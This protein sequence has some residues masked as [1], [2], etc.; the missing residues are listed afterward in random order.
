MS[1]DITCRLK[2]V[3]RRYLDVGL[4]FPYDRVVRRVGVTVSGAPPLRGVRVPFGSSYLLWDGRIVRVPDVEEIESDL[5]GPGGRSDPPIFLTTKNV[6]SGLGPIRLA[7][8]YRLSTAIR[9]VDHVLMRAR[10]TVI[11]VCMRVFPAA[12][13]YGAGGRFR[14]LI[15]RPADHRSR[16]G[17]TGFVSGSFP[18]SPQ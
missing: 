14:G 15:P 5:T 8:R 17:L 1:F 12:R 13:G 10:S 3:F 2:P 7:G 16:A 11:H 4:S 18:P 9:L 6:E